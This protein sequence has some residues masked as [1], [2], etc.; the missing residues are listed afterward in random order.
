MDAQRAPA[1]LGRR[2]GPLVGGGVVVG[3]LLV[4]LVALAVTTASPGLW[5]AA[6][7][8]AALGLGG[9]AVLL[10]STPPAAPVPG[11]APAEDTAT[12][13]PERPAA[14]VREVDDLQAFFDAP[15]GSPTVLPPATPPTAP[16]A[17]IPT[18]TPAPAPALAAAPVTRPA[19]H[20]PRRPVAALATA[21]VALVVAAGTLAV[22]TDHG[23]R[24]DD[25]G[26]DEGRPAAAATTRTVPTTASS[27]PTTTR[28][29]LTAAAAGDL[30]S[31]SVDPGRDGFT[32]RAAFEGIV[33]EPRAVGATVSYPRLDV[34][35]DGTTGVAHL[36]LTTWNCITATPPVDPAAAGCTASL[37]EYADL[38]TPALE[39]REVAGEFE[40]S[41][42]FETYTRPNGSSPVYTGRSYPITVEAGPDGRAED[43]TAPL[44]GDLELGTS[45][46]ATT[47][48][49]TANTVTAGG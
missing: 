10:A 26:R 28:A 42:D 37:T 25:R 17:P 16:P 8:V 21:A 12:G 27:T 46:A 32:A 45:T 7:L 24:R 19:P 4:V 48:D 11:P 29:P 39:L 41:G 3:V 35:S 49:R 5:V 6:L 13:S 40:L 18:P 31:T 15:P 38:P 34:S 43:G 33:L 22:L 23:G 9:A 14:A 1:P 20:S 47:A 36:E 30:A 44:V 2:R